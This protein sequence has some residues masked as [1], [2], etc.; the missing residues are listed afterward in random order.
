MRPEILTNRKRTS[1][2]ARETPL[3]RR[4]KR[5]LENWVP[6][7]LNY[8]EDWPERPNCG[9]FFGGAHWYGSDTASDRSSCLQRLRIL[10]NTI[11]NGPDARKKN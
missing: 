9:H 11:R 2:P 3:S 1:V 10:P 4:Y 6:I 7:G 8:F 5:I